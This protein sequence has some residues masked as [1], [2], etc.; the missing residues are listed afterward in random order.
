[1]RRGYAPSAIQ[2]RVTARSTKDGQQGKRAENALCSTHCALRGRRAARRMCPVRA[3]PAGA[4]VAQ[5]DGPR[6]R[7]EG[8]WWGCVEG[9]GGGGWGAKQV[10]C[11][12]R[13]CQVNPP[14]LSMVKSGAGVDT[15]WRVKEKRGP[16]SSQLN[17]SRGGNH[18]QVA[19]T[20]AP[21]SCRPV[22][23]KSAM[24]TSNYDVGSGASY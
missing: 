11:R 4:A 12:C 9:V 8:W 16:P 18:Q 17:Q 15:L 24:R 1:M 5:S 7:R 6:R 3:G 23:S 2:R 10:E 22:K 19:F 21:S 20:G 13:P 14:G